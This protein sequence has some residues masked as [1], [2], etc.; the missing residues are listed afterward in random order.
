MDR[1]VYHDDMAETPFW[2]DSPEVLLD[3]W[4]EVIPYG[5]MSN[6]RKANA[7]T[8]LAVVITTMF[9]LNRCLPSPATYDPVVVA[10]L[11]LTVA[12]IMIAMRRNTSLDP[13]NDR[14]TFWPGP[15]L[16]DTPVREEGTEETGGSVYDSD[17]RSYDRA[18]SS[19]TLP[20]ENADLKWLVGGDIRRLQ[21]ENTE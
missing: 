9:L 15:P 17:K 2:T 8:R 19:V 13:T 18:V 1:S 21:F 14:E 3:K 10:V 16:M 11:F 20:A 5:W 12:I 6:G 7:L 4:Y